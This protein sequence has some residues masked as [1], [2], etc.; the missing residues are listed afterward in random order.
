[1]LDER[2]GL[3]GHGVY[4]ECRGQFPGQWLRTANSGVVEHHHPVVPGEGMNQPRIPDLHG[5]GVAHDQDQRGAAPDDPVPDGAEPGMS[6][7]HWRRHDRG[8]ARCQPRC[9][10]ARAQRDGHHHHGQ[11]QGGSSLQRSPASHVRLLVLPLA[12]VTSGIPVL[13]TR[14]ISELAVHV[15]GGSVSSARPKSRFDTNHDQESPDRHDHGGEEE[16]SLPPRH[17]DHH[18]PIW[19]TDSSCPAGPAET[20]RRQ[21]PRSRAGIG[22]LTRP[23]HKRRAVTSTVWQ[24]TSWNQDGSATGPWVLVNRW[25]APDLVGPERRR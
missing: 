22:G 17:L 20:W 12:A 18:D 2:T 4:G 23:C 13:L 9:G 14:R 7:S 5:P 21:A 15:L 8:R 6:D 19:T 16:E 3:V 11:A 25:T 1:M 10:A 24:L